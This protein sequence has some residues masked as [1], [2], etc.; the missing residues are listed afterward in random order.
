MNV[1]WAHQVERKW[2]V[3]TQD[4]P[5]RIQPVLQSVNSE[6]HSYSLQEAESYAEHL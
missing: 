2:L 5:A 4:M 1:K 3:Q 6:V